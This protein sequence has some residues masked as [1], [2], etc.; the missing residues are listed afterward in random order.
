MRNMIT[1][2]FGSGADTDYNDRLKSGTSFS[3]SLLLDENL[4]ERKKLLGEEFAQYK[5]IYPN[6]T[7]VFLQSV[8][9]NAELAKK[10]LSPDD[11]SKCIRYYERSSN[12]VDYEEI[13]KICHKWFKAL[14]ANDENNTQ[15]FFFEHAVFFDSMDGKFNSLRHLAHDTNAKRIINAYLCVYILM[16]KSMFDIDE[17]FEWNYSNIINLLL[18]KKE[19]LTSNKDD[20][21]YNILR[22]SKLSSSDYHVATTNYTPYVQDSTSEEVIYLHGCMTWFEDIKQL[23]I[24]DCADDEERK[25]IIS[26]S[27]NIIPF[28]LIPSGV[29]PIICSK[30][31]KAFKNFIDVLNSSDFLVV[32]G[33]KFNSEDNHINSIINEWLK[34]C[35]SKMVYFNFEELVD[36]RRFYWLPENINID[37]IEFSN[38][39][40][41][42]VTTG[43]IMNVIVNK[44][45]SNDAFESFLTNYRG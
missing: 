9:S 8:A 3:K 32:V 24:Y 18:D 34:K 27:K 30:Q 26:N 16:L 22:K 41:V 14:K 2:L 12:I 33:Y 38:E 7:K 39:K 17:N 25:N 19:K 42:V 29:K 10:M 44:S 4:S 37:K 5:F 6:S 40:R 13:R 1:F 23:M 43:K 21:Y 11:V 36:F 28:I 45:N 20:N 31:I 35:N 15:K